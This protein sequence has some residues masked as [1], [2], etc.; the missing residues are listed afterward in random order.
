MWFVERA[1]PFDLDRDDVAGH[2]R[3]RDRRRTGQDHVAWHEGDEAGDVGHE[4]VHVPGHLGRRSVL[5]H[6]AVDEGAHRLVP[7]VPVFDEPW[8]DRAEGVGP[9]HPQHRAGVGIAE[10]M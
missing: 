1:E 6:V 4:V 2:D 3:S 8:P 5:A 7:E 10:V 9:L